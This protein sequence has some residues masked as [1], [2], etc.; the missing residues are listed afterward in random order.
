MVSRYEI[1]TTKLCL[2]EPRGTDI[3]LSALLDRIDLERRPRLV[4]VRAPAG[5][6]K[7]TFA[8]QVVRTWGLPTAWYR[9]G[10]EDDNASVFFRHVLS[11]LGRHLPTLLHDPNFS[12]QSRPF[13]AN[14]TCLVA[15]L[16]NAL[17]HVPPPGMAI[18]LEDCHC[19][20]NTSIR[21]F[22]EELVAHAPPLISFVITGRGQLPVSTSKYQ[23]AQEAVVLGVDDL[24]FSDSETALLV[25]NALSHVDPYVAAHI[26]REYEGWPALVRL[27]VSDRAA[28]NA[29][30]TGE[31]PQIVADYL[32]SEVVGPHPEPIRQFMKATSILDFLIAELCDAFLEMDDSVQILRSL[33]DEQL[34]LPV[35]SEFGPAFRY[36]NPLR[37]FLQSALGAERRTLL[38]RAGECERLMGRVHRAIDHF[39]TAGATEQAVEAIVEAGDG[40]IASGQHQLLKRWIE[41][42]PPAAV[43]ANPW[44]SMWWGAVNTA[45]GR[46]HAGQAYLESAL[47]K[48]RRQGDRCGA[49]E[50]QLRLANNLL[51]RGLAG[52]SRELIDNAIPI[53]SAR[54]PDLASEALSQKAIALALCGHMNEAVSI[55]SEAFRLA[56][57]SGRRCVLARVAADL[58]VVYYL[59]GDHLEILH[60]RD[61]AFDGDV[62]S[63]R[64]GSERLA[65]FSKSEAFAAGLRSM[66][67][68][69]EAIELARR[70]L[71]YKDRQGLMEGLPSTYCQMGLVCAD[72]GEFGRAEEC[73][74]RAID[75]AAATGGYQLVVAL[76]LRGLARVRCLQ[77]KLIEGQAL[78]E[79]G[80]EVARSL[81]ETRYAEILCSI[82]ALILRMLQGDYHS[83]LAEALSLTRAASDLGFRH[84][85]ALA[86]GLLAAICAAASDRS[87]ASEHASLCLTASARGN[88]LQELVTYFQVFAPVLRIGVELGI[89]GAFVQRIL[90]RAGQPA[91]ELLAEMASHPDPQV[92]H[93]AEVF[94]A[95]AEGGAANPDTVS[96]DEARPDRPVHA[97]EGLNGPVHWEVQSRTPVQADVQRGR[98][99]HPAAE[100]AAAHAPWSPDSPLVLV[101]ENYYK[102]NIQCFGPFIVSAR[103]DEIPLHEWRTTK[104][105]DLLAYLVHS[106]RPVQSDV[107]ME[108]LW[109][110]C[111]LDQTRAVLHT[112]LYYLRKALHAIT[113]SEEIVIFGGGHYRLAE[114][115]YTTDVDRFTTLLSASLSQD[116]AT[117]TS[118]ELLEKAIALYKGDYLEALDY[119]WVGAEQRRLKRVCVEARERL[120]QHYLS[121][122]SYSRALPHALALVEDCPLSEEAHMTAMRVYACLGDLAAVKE[123]YKSMVDLFNEELGSAPSPEVRRLYYSLFNE[124]R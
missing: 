15:P 121:V 46:L 25:S 65:A 101:R 64:S 94:L 30:G 37:R 123:Q 73:F 115:C 39:V 40:L 95:M 58:S 29:T 119:A 81:P 50:A 88:C 17:R 110:E 55:A 7:S 59:S 8:A 74:Y 85:A 54:K 103:G 66:G 13:E 28:L 106:G 80:L 34:L 21:L 78:I 22:I 83:T 57:L 32:Q 24:R 71:D 61:S 100:T 41:A 93:R 10:R 102:I 12:L 76:S 114:G 69:Q 86:H 107:I 20:G 11:G 47:A 124:N 98:R 42:L 118:A 89:E 90:S 43:S 1:I 97:E 53:L 92:R 87:A 14:P 96:T 104:A 6:G 108:D 122:G 52:K 79:Q 27:L 63:I 49:A 111:D 5:Y 2:P 9:L 113:G 67:E 44:L 112:N 105:R 91:L 26:C 3:D 23:A 82:T 72:Q 4:A 18:V 51:W 120:V 116:G 45:Q 48:F 70:S 31:L 77:G 16:V 60:V 33:R 99:V 68:L 56:Q 75:I 36:L 109:P 19:V 62:D 84:A 35:H 117:V 38:I